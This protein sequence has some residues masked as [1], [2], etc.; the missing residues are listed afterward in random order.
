MPDEAIEAGLR[1]YVTVDILFNEAGDVDSVVP[2]S[3]KHPVLLEAVLAVARNWKIEPPIEAGR[4]V[5][6]TVRQS[7]QFEV[8]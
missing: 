2:R 4:R 3:Y 1:D 7:F 6:T 5:K 8:E